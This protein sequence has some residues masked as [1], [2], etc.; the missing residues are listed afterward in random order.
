MAES[1]IPGLD[2]D[3]P[4]E[5]GLLPDSL[6]LK[7]KSNGEAVGFGDQKPSGDSNAVSQKEVRVVPRHICKNGG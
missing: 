1:L 4:A 5:R 3:L 6:R 2:G 7:K